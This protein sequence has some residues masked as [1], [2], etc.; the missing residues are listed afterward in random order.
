[1]KAL[2]LSGGTGS[3][4]RP[5]SHS[6]PKQLIPV[7]GRPVLEH[8]LARVRELGVHEVGI[9]VG[10]HAGQIREAI[11]DGTRLGLSITYIAQDQPRGLGHTVQ[12]A[13]QFLGSDDFVMYLGD[14][15]LGNDVTG[16][17]DE[18]RRTR[19]AAQLLVRKVG[20]PRSF[21]VADVGPGGRVRGLAEKPDLPVSDLAVVGVYF[22]TAAI[23]AAIDAV[24]VSRRGELELTD[25]LQ[26]L[27]DSGVPVHASE[28]E[29]YWKDVGRIGDLLDCNSHMLGVMRGSV[30]GYVDPASSVGPHVTIE[31][32]AKVLRSHV[33]GPSFIGA[34][35]V[36][37]DSVIGP[38]TSVGADCLLRSAHI[39]DSIVMQ[40]AQIVDTAGLT[41]SLVGRRAVIGRNESGPGQQLIV[42]D[43]ARI[44]FL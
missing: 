22:L 13:R 9:V 25:A 19:V 29:G 23:H 38:H 37:E 27:V 44:S 4:M 11:G 6:M 14:N 12:V 36:V 35:T 26:W 10:E 41:R 43:D 39:T 21:G 33:R 20:D 8:V 5:L 30:A 16:V 3:R 18:F 40:G 28:Y 32:G 1:M 24:P 7:A 2:V 17:A 34:N 31:P 42:G 15:I